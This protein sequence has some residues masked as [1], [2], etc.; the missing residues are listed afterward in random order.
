LK[1]EV[2]N[3]ALSPLG[4]QRISWSAQDMPVLQQ[5]RQRFEKEKPLVGI[6]LAACC[7]ITTETANLAITLQAAGCESVLIASNPLSTQDDVAAWLVKEAQIPTFAIK[8]ESISTYNQHVQE[9]ISFEPDV[10]IDDG[11]D[12]VAT[13]TQQ[14][15]EKAQKLI[16][17]TEE[18]TTG[19]TRLLSMERD[20]ALHFP[21]IAVNDSQTKYLFDNRYGTGQSTLDGI[22]RATNILLSG[23]ILV[24]LGFGWCGRGIANRA[25]GLGARVVVCEVDPLRA[26]EAVMEGYQVLPIQEAASLGD[27][28]VTVTGNRHVINL[29]HMRQMKNNALVCNSGHFDLEIDIESLSKICPSPQEVRPFVERYALGQKNICILAGGRLINLAA[30]EGH[31]SAVMDLSFANQALAVEHLVRQQGK[32]AKK[33][34]K[35]PSDLD[36]ELARLK[37]HSMNIPIDKLSPEMHEYMNS[38]K[39]GT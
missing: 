27:I 12:L 25:R 22:L 32:L 31:P 7:H 1:Y 36:Q 19:I 28:F 38:W 9:A 30:A 17:S 21:A 8:G 33:V 35:L 24:V 11:C 6:R 39:L 2:A 10:I 16:G 13:L 29:E 23:K 18:T 15:P 5:I 37:L 26:L 20:G 34:Q 3:L 14:F 4:E